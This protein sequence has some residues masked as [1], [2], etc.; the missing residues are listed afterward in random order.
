MPTVWW[1]R[2]VSSAAL[3]GA[4]SAVVWKRVNSRPGAASRSA[5]GVLMAPPKLEAAP[6]PMSSSRM[7]K[8]L[9]DPAGGRASSIGGKTVSGS[10][11]S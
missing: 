10:L 3:V 7:I 5:V 1:F 11:A 4:Q 6:K 9:G 8:T 2:P